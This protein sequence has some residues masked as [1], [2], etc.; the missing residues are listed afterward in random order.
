MMNL[1][2]TKGSKFPI[3]RPS[4]VPSLMHRAFFSDDSRQRRSEEL[5]ALRKGKSHAREKGRPID[6]RLRGDSGLGGQL[7]RPIEEFWGENEVEKEAERQRLH[8]KVDVAPSSVTGS[9]R[10]HQHAKL[11]TTNHNRS[12]FV[13]FFDEVDAK[14]ELISKNRFRNQISSSSSGRGGTR[15][16]PDKKTNLDR[17][18][19]A[20]QD[21]AGNTSSSIGSENAPKSIFEAFPLKPKAEI[22]PNAYDKQ[23]YEQYHSIMEEITLSDRFSRKQTRKPISEDVFGPVVEWLLKDSKILPYEYK[24]LKDAEMNGISMNVDSSNEISESELKMKWKLGK[25]FRSEV[26]MNGTQANKFHRELKDQRK[27]FLEKTGFSP[28]QML[29]AERALGNLASNCAKMIKSVPLTVAW[30]K[31]KEA[32]MIPSNDTLNVFLYVTGTMSSSFVSSK[33]SS[34]KKLSAVMSILGGDEQKQ[35]GEDDIEA[36]PIDFP[37]EL[38]LFHDLLYAPTEKSVSLR[39]K[40]LV[41]IGDANGAEF[42]LDSFPVSYLNIIEI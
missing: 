7:D 2:K 16:T 34:G 8:K 37:T 24:T 27:L 35:D 18:F 23:D 30:E 19:G 20:F 32:G 13:S 33:I 14:M 42:L 11:P 4:Q 40:R 3:N 26:S 31:S 9:N 17:L 5:R 22:D 28:E 12:E 21:K 39:V 41:S 36:D 25:A 6:Y 15:N 1:I 38:A 29:L 10:S